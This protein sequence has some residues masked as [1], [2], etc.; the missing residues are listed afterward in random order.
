MKL[1]LTKRTLLY[2][3]YW[4]N[5]FDC[6]DEELWYNK[7]ECFS[8]K[9]IADKDA[10]IDIKLEENELDNGKIIKNLS[11]DSFEILEN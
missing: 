11:R 8:G 7:G 10:T 4:Y 3:A 1:K 9:I 6:G 2:F 5:E